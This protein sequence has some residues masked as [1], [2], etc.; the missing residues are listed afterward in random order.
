MVPLIAA[1]ALAAAGSILGAGINAYSSN[2]MNK[3]I[4]REQMAWQQAENERTFQRN[5]EQWNRENQYNTPSAQMERL[6]AAGLNPNLVYGNGSGTMQSASSP[7]LQA[8]HSIMP[9]LRPYLDT[10]GISQMILDA[11]MKE[12]QIK[13]LEADTAGKNIGND[14]KVFDLGVSKEVRQATIEKAFQELDYSTFHAQGEYT[15]NQ[16]QLKELELK[17]FYKALE[18]NK[19]QL[20]KSLNDAQIKQLTQN[21]ENLL[22]THDWNAYKQ[23]VMKTT[24][25]NIDTDP[26]YLKI[27]GQLLSGVMQRFGIK[28]G[29]IGMP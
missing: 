16:L 11:K 20:T 10:A 21:T 15:R 18:A 28:L 26:Y 22:Q 13:N 2:Q 9:Q 3:D 25:I 8:A 23:E 1:G 6:H 7:Q 5:L 27:I 12:A 14:M 24:G 29:S 17:D 19:F 4:A